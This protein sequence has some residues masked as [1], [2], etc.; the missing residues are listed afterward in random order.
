VFYYATNIIRFSS[1]TD[2]PGAYHE[3]KT[4]GELPTE[5]EHCTSK[6]AGQDFALRR[7]SGVATTLP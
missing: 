3:S 2:H 7:K 5:Q 4:R 6:V 1:L